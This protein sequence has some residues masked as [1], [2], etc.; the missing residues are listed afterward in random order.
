MRPKDL[1]YDYTICKN[2][3]H[4]VWLNNKLQSRSL[5]YRSQV[6]PELIQCYQQIP[7]KNRHH[8]Q[9]MEDL[10][11]SKDLNNTLLI[12]SNAIINEISNAFPALDGI[13]LDD[14]TFNTWR[15]AIPK[16]LEKSIEK[17][18]RQHRLIRIDIYQYQSIPI[19]S[20]QFL[21]I[22]SFPS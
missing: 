5:S 9:G 7:L 6:L 8:S 19:N 20:Y 13:T 4:V 14:D 11:D 1:L 15:N 12:I 18:D 22:H 16:H 3:Y 2:H 21:S 17:G 10:S